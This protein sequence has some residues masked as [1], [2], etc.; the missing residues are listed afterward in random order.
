MCSG[1]LPIRVLPKGVRKG[2]PGMHWRAGLM[3]GVP[4][5]ARVPLPACADA[6]AAAAETVAAATIALP[7]ATAFSCVACA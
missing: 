1:R 6:A 4:V 7:I 5:R 3:P 2:G